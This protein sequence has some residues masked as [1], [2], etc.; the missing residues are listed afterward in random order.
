MNPQHP[1]GGGSQPQVRH[2]PCEGR[3]GVAPAP[4]AGGGRMAGGAL[5][6]LGRLAPA[7]LLLLGLG[8]CSVLPGGRPGRPPAAPIADRPIHLEGRCA[9]TEDDG[10]REQATLRVR[11][12]VVQALS[13]QLW[14]GRRGSCSFD[15]A[16]FTQTRRSPHIELT[17][18]NGSGCKL[19]IWQDPRRV[20]LAHSGCERS[21]SPGIYDQAWPV[22]FDPATGGCA[23]P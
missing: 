9:Q 1:L 11:N 16:A 2:L 4:A 12:N 15:Q 23:R 17:A 19:L 22:M 8:A 6:R 21:C 20:T 5:R 13:W 10:F 14:V 7:A 3:P 18:R